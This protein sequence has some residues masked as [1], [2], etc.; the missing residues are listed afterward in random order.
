MVVI[1]SL[2]SIPSASKHRTNVNVL[3]AAE[4][5]VRSRSRLLDGDELQLGRKK[6]DGDMIDESATRLLR[7]SITLREISILLALLCNMVGIRNGTQSLQLH[8]WRRQ[9]A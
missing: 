9:M 2:R 8:F 5:I 6:E 1:S 4:N 7:Y 3:G